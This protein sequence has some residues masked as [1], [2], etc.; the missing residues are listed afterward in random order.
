MARTAPGEADFIQV[1][2]WSS[3]SLLYQVNFDAMISRDQSPKIFEAGWLDVDKITFEWTGPGNLCCSVGYA[4]F[5]DFT[6]SVSTVPLPAALPLML[7]GLGVLGFA[8]RRR[9][10]NP[11]LMKQAFLVEKSNA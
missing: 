1:T 8:A 9:K 6:Y 10:V 3:E 5:D 4:T 7:S 2:G 11:V